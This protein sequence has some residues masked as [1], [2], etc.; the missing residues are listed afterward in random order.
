MTIHQL[1]ILLALFKV[2]L[3]PFIKEAIILGLIGAVIGLTV[4]FAG[5][6]YFTTEIGSVFITD[7]TKFVY[8]IILVLGV[9]VLITVLSTIFATWRFLRSRIDT[10]YYS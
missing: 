8:L 3:M 5:W 10:L 1:L 4:L 2:I 9:G 7:Q 6:Y